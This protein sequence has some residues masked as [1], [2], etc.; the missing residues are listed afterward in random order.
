M[1][2]VRPGNTGQHLRHLLCLR[3][4]AD[5]GEQEEKREADLPSTRCVH[6]VAGARAG[7][8][9]N[10]K[11]DNEDQQQNQQRHGMSHG[12]REIYGAES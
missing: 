4:M 2:A 9:N 12:R 1:I 5:A 8:A 7:N 11:G 10:P 6:S 3:E